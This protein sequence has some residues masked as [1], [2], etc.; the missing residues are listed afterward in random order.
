MADEIDNL[1][2]LLQLQLEQKVAEARA[3]LAAA[4][5]VTGVCIWCD[6]PDV[7]GRF[8]DKYCEE[9]YRKAQWAQQQRKVK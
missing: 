5:P 2:P 4:P 7:E 3:N 9:D 1:D 6:T 8:C